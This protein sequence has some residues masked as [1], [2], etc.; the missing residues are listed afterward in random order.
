MTNNPGHDPLAAFEAAA[1]KIAA[2]RA[3]SRSNVQRATRVSDHARTA[4][5]VARSARNEITVTA[6][7]GGVIER[8]EFDDAA[9]DLAP[10]E[11]SRLAVR[12]IAQAQHDAAMSFASTAALEFGSDSPVAAALRSDAQQAFPPPDAV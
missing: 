2:V 10:A 8:I 6:R 11:L 9:F 1:A 4:Q 5:A 7:A 3:R 12:T